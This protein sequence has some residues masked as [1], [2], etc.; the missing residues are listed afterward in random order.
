MRPTLKHPTQILALA[1]VLLI[2]SFVTPRPETP[3]ATA[4]PRAHSA[5]DEKVR[6][7][8]LGLFHSRQFE[9]SAT[10]GQALVLQ[11]GSQSLV[12]EKSSG[13][14]SVTIQ[15]FDAQV[16]VTTGRRTLEASSISVAGR[17]N[18]PVDFILAIPAKIRRHYHGTMQVEPSG[19]TLLAILTL[20]L[21]AAVASVVAAESTRGAPVEALKAQAI[22]TRSYFV[23]GR[24]RHADFDFC[25][26]T[27]CQFLRDPPAPEST[28]AGAVEATRG[29]ILEYDLH[30]FPAMY[31]RSCSG[32]TRTPADLGLPAGAYPYY[33]V[34]CE[35][36]RRHPAHWTARISAHDAETLHSSDESSRLNIDRRLGWNTVPSNDFSAT[37][38]GDQIV[39]EGTGRGHGMGLCQSGA[40]AM[41]EQGAS[42]RDILS[43]YYP[44]TTVVPWRK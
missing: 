29:S 13:V 24:G 22:V 27:H 38:D 19:S 3:L 14:E 16:V 41:A 21:E 43:H 33:S 15:L 36:C 9:L 39:V 10:A 31:T 20:D 35:Y 8:V 30:P 37:K 28:V 4:R 42:F 5:F 26:T 2:L 25:D 34:P 12:L 7:G 11:V 23:S 40:K 18:E 44:N 17:A 1:V 32:R 6:V